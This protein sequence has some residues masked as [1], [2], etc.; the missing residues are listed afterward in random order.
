MS[1][2]ARAAEI[3]A[4][5][6][7]LDPETLGT[8][9]IASAIRAR[10]LALRMNDDE[11]YRRLLGSETEIASLVEEVVVP[12]SW[13]F[14][15]P[16][17]FRLLA[18]A[19]RG[20]RRAGDT[21]EVLSVP[22]ARGEEAFSAAIALLTAGIEPERFSV[23]GIDVSRRCLEEARS[24]RIRRWSRRGV[25][26]PHLVVSDDGSAQVSRTV[27]DRVRFVSDNVMESR[28]LSSVSPQHAI[29]C[30]N[31]LVYLRPEVRR[32]LVAR[33]RDRLRPEGVL[34]LGP[35]EA[36]SPP[37]GLVGWGPREAF[38]FRAEG[39]PGR[40]SESLPRGRRV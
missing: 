5:R 23:V 37:A 36:A 21:I 19:A 22:C 32:S 6:I 39:S 2:V 20:W 33:L 14:R 31:L 24:G 18:D 29:F 40:E 1:L 9:A 26:S 12:E 15:E 30:R 25:D 28:F 8:E 34:F 11:S 3:L 27:M 10:K 4:H 17:S 35:A 38:G 7:G 13:L 16:A